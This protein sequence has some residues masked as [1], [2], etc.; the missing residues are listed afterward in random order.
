MKKTFLCGL[1]CAVTSLAA[2]AGTS[3]LPAKDR[4]AVTFSKPSSDTRM[5][6]REVK[7]IS[8]SKNAL[9]TC[10]YSVVFVT[11]GG[12]T[13]GTRTWETQAGPGQTF[14]S[15]AQFFATQRYYLT[16]AH[17]LDLY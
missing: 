11:S 10:R 6:V 13:L 12:L 14:S 16:H 3:P 2:Y 17:G 9:V 4:P 8:G 5:A 15:C 1:I 7:E